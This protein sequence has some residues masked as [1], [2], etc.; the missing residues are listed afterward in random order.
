MWIELPRLVQ[1]PT[2]YAEIMLALNPVF[3]VLG[4]VFP[5]LVFYYMGRRLASAS[6]YWS[7]LVSVF[8]SS[9]V[10]GLLVEI[11]NLGVWYLRGADYAGWQFSLYV[12]W[13]VISS[14][15]SGVLIVGAAGI[16]FAYYRTSTAQESARLSPDQLGQG[17]HGEDGVA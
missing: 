5:F 4:T 13:L 2:M 12:I 10:G 9:W 15:V 8:F 17:A 14:A 3:M 11:L 6:E 16:L 1:H 7:A